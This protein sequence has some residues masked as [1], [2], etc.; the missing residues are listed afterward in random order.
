MA[1]KNRGNLQTTIN[2]NLPNNAAGSITPELHREVETD[3]NDSMYNKLSDANLVGLKIYDPTR[4]YTSNEAT[5]YNDGAGLQVWLSNKATTGTF[6][7]A[8]WDLTEGS[9][10]EAPIDGVYYARHQGSWVNVGAALGSALSLI[11]VKVKADLPAP[12]TGV[13]T[14]EDGIH[15]EVDALID[16]G[17]D[18]IVANT[19]NTITTTNSASNGFTSTNAVILEAPAGGNLRL[20]NISLVG[21]AGTTGL[22]C[23][24]AVA[25]TIYQCSFINCDKGLVINGLDNLFMQDSFFSANNT[26]VEVQGSGIDYLQIEGCSFSSFVNYG[27][28]LGT[29]TMN[30]LIVSGNLFTGAS[31]SFNISG[32]ASSG[33][34][35]K[36]ARYVMNNFN[37]L[38]TG[39]ENITTKDIKHE[40][41]YNDGA[42]CNSID[43]GGLYT[44]N[45]ST[46]VT[47]NTI[48]VFEVIAPTYTLDP[49]SARFSNVT[50]NQ[51][52]CDSE[53]CNAGEVTFNITGAKVGG[54]GTSLYAVAIFE[55]GTILPASET[56]IAVNN[57]IDTPFIGSCLVMLDNTKYYDVRVANLDDTADFLVTHAQINAK[58]LT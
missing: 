51:L 52:K 34:I 45:I 56:F 44:A 36:R 30:S 41:I 6:I 33:N 49:N 11:I 37:G 53:Y 24:D 9:V 54:G 7:P 31:G 35:G 21:G 26:A 20:N 1:V 46:T 29:A 2:D 15:Y 4:S 12:V 17:S 58:R 40:F 16:L 57:T 42:V 22:L 47:I 23:G 5:V 50:N 25:T 48:G 38:A 19:D 3:I 27:I 32:L 8:D 14:L 13:I 18:K 28:N 10:N 43:A 39:L 55:N